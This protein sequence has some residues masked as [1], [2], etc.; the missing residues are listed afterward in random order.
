MER[1]PVVQ[2]RGVTKVFPGLFNKVVANNDVE[3]EVSQGEIHVIVG[4]NGAGKSTLMNILYGLVHPDKGEISL[5]GEIVQIDNPKK[6]IDLGVGMIHQHFMLVPSFTVGENVILGKEPTKLGLIDDE[7][8]HSEIHKLCEML[9]FELDL[10]AQIWDTPVGVQQRVEILKA[11][12]RGAK[13]LILDEPTAVLTPQEVDVLFEALRKLAANG[14]TV[15]MITHKLPE[16]MDIA[17]RVTVMRDGRVVDVVERAQLNES[18]LAEKMTGREWHPNRFPRKDL[19]QEVNEV[20]RI[21][22][23]FCRDDRGVMA[24]RGVNFDIREGEIVGIAGVSHNGQEELS[25]AL[26]GQR[27]IESGR[28]YFKGKDISHLSVKSI[29]DLGIGHIPDD[30][31]GEGCAREASVE[32]NM[33][34]ATHDHQPLGNRFYMRTSRIRTWVE[35]RIQTYAIKVDHPEVP[36]GSLSGGNVQKAIVAR[37]IAQTGACMIAEQPSRG[38]D[39]GAAEAIYHRIMELRDAGMAI[40]LV[41]MDLAEILR[42]SDRVL[43]IFNGEIVGERDPEQTDQRELGLLMAGITREQELGANSEPLEVAR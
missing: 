12:Y 8:V 42:L 40:L 2:M 19:S 5:F 29:R 38:I 28:V 24:V 30:R 18:I 6:A 37:E 39:I 20:L 10:D 36:I 27:P 34:M 25:E 31:Y 23:L 21:E 15:I 7:R 13:I 11:L 16:V 22:E 1:E 9:N 26:M 43:V 32:K 17:D 33:I 3:L 14:T 35:E 41:S 4:E